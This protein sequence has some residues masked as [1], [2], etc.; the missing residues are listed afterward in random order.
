MGRNCDGIGG[1][2]LEIVHYGAAQVVL[3][4][5]PI[6]TLTRIKALVE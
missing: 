6:M 4:A 5:A 2:R 3:A 1:D